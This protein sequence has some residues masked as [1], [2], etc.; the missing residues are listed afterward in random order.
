MKRKAKVERDGHRQ[1]ERGGYM[2]QSNIKWFAQVLW[3]CLSDRRQQIIHEIY[4]GR[5]KTFV[6]VEKAKKIPDKT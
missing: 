5:W 1:I 4:S 6:A 3:V 2:P